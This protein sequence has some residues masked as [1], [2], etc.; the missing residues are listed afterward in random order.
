[1]PFQ[2]ARSQNGNELQM[3]NQGRLCL[4]FQYPYLL[5]SVL[6]ELCV[7]QHRQHTVRGGLAA[8]AWRNA[9]PIPTADANIVAIRQTPVISFSMNNR[10]LPPH[11]RRRPCILRILFCPLSFSFFVFL[12]CVKSPCKWLL[13]QCPRPRKFTSGVYF[14]D[15]FHVV[16]RVADGSSLY[17]NMPAFGVKV[18]SGIHVKREVVI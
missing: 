8:G 3:R 15:Q 10:G 18:T 13:R 12:S 14:P 1:M 5:L 6:R 2:V 4:S 9:R 7:R 16:K 11:P 17:G